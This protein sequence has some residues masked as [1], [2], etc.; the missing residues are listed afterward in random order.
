MPNDIAT[1]KE[2]ELAMIEDV[3]I[4]NNK[5]FQKLFRV[6]LFL[7][8]SLNLVVPV[9]LSIHKRKGFFQ[10]DEYYQG[11]NVAYNKAYNIPASENTW[12]WNNSLRSYLFPF[13]IEIFGYRLFAQW[14][15]SVIFFYLNYVRQL[16]V[17][18]NSFVFHSEFLLACSQ[19]IGLLND[20][21]HETIAQCGIS[22]GPVVIMCLLGAVTDY[23]TIALIF[24][25]YTL[26]QKQKTTDRMRKTEANH[27]IK[28]SFLLVTTNMFSVF[29][30][31]RSFVNTFELFL[32]T[33]AFY[34]FD[35]NNEN[36]K[37]FII[38]LTLGFISILQ[39]P[40]N[41]FVWI[42]L[43]S[44]KLTNGLSNQRVVKLAR[45]LLFS[46]LI[47]AFV[48]VSTDFY[49]YGKITIP[50][51][52]FVKF[53]FFKDLSKF[54][55][56]APMSF[57]IFQS[58]P[59]LNGIT[60]PYYLISLINFSKSHAILKWLH[61]LLLF[62]LLMFSIIDHKEFRFLY[63]VQQTYLLLG[64]IQY[65]KTPIIASG[66]GQI[67]CCNSLILGW[68][69]AYFNESGVIELCNYLNKSDIKSLSVLMPCHSIPGISYL[70]QYKGTIWQLTCEPP[71][72]LLEETDNQILNEKLD[73]YLDISDHFYLDYDK[74]I[75]QNVG[76]GK[77][78]SWTE[79]VAMFSNLAD[80]IYSTHLL[81]NGYVLEM[82]W[83]NSI[84]HWDD[85]REGTVELYCKA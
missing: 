3:E 27:V 81:P 11:L 6:I 51:I 36:D 57:H 30:Q 24:K 65:L 75:D 31:T 67:I 63:P 2:T 12:E 62:N 40:T 13:I 34:F 7:K 23:F 5:N 48:T 69:L 41:I 32:N 17:E 83:F 25:I 1:E 61:A 9:F 18:L 38:S 70:D 54:Y 59:L 71:L 43:G 58:V 79:C 60:L 39:R 42:V 37:S 82:S 46:F 74:W 53:N 80:N 77:L 16:I 52:T 50:F 29:F 8:V 21:L 26:I 85:R 66:L 55:G 28:V 84:K 20:D 33:T 4:H 14:L 72:H 73:S 15:P 78:H 22:Y 35:W 56:S 64:I 68:I 49:F 44:Y 10:P 45:H 19:Y 76:S 47:A